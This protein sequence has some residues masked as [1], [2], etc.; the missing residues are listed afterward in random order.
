MF[1]R[2]SRKTSRLGGISAAEGICVAIQHI[3]QRKTI[4][5]AN[6]WR[7]DIRSI[8][9]TSVLFL[10]HKAAEMHIRTIWGEGGNEEEA[11][12]ATFVIILKT[13]L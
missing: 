13:V 12:T 8:F 2:L 10:L 6:Q 3:L 5:Q 1:F 4:G 11:V 9:H 7:E